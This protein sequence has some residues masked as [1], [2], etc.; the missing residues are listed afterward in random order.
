[1]HIYQLNK[2]Y[3]LPSVFD[4][5]NGFG[6]PS[7]SNFATQEGLLALSPA[8]L[9]GV[10]VPPIPFL[11]LL[12]QHSDKD[13]VVIPTPCARLLLAGLIFFVATFLF[14]GWHAQ[15]RWRS[16]IKDAQVRITWK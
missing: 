2:T 11:F 7:G 9:L 1:M 8:G 5:S 6:S 14:V 4:G 15:S 12:L 13:R 10:V 3:M 16:E